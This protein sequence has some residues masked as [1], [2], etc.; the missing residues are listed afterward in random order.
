VELTRKNA[1]ATSP[2]FSLLL[3][4]RRL[5]NGPRS[6]SCTLR[7]AWHPVDLAQPDHAAA[8]GQPSTELVCASSGSALG[9]ACGSPPG[10]RGD[11]TPRPT[12]PI[13]AVLV[14][15]H[16]GDLPQCESRE[17]AEG[18]SWLGGGSLRDR[19]PPCTKARTITRCESGS[20]QMHGQGESLHHHRWFP[21]SLRVDGH[22]RARTKIA[23]AR[24][25]PDYLCSRGSFTCY[26]MLPSQVPRRAGTSPSVRSWQPN[27]ANTAGRSAIAG[28]MF[29]LVIL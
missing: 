25:L 4:V 11:A 29:D 1:L 19:V 5:G 26:P 2:G 7:L 8:R 22:P 16:P 24:S 23:S 14:A 20:V 15:G 18:I 28:R 9:L 21:V 6:R 13:A 27:R 17:A 12:W 10:G 3:D